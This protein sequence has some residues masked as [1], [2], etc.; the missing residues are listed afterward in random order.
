MAINN[1]YNEY[2]M[3]SGDKNYIELEINSV[4]KELDSNRIL[5]EE[6]RT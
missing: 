4:L 3:Q 5:S 6:D 1:Q 2:F